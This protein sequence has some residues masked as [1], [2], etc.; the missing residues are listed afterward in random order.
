MILD[1]NVFV[2]RLLPRMVIR[3]LSSTEM[4]YY[5]RPF[6]NPGEDRRSTWPR[7]IPLDGE[8]ADVAEVVSD[9]S[10]WLGQSPVPKLYIHC[11]PGALDHGRQREFCRTWPNQTEV[12]VKGIHFVQEDSPNEIG[13]AVADFVRTL[14]RS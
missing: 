3:Q 9:Y 5:R 13:A 14:P 12:T 2:E 1:D 8:P 11:E 6:A 4:D 7:Q 10:N